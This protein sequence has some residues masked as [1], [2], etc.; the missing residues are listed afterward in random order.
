VRVPKNA[1]G[2][3]NQ[4]EDPCPGNPPKRVVIG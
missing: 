3:T 4:K 2:L 1:N